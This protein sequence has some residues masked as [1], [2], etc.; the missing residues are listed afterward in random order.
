MAF[1]ENP[2]LKKKRFLHL[3]STIPQLQS[4]QPILR[5]TP[6]KSP[7]TFLDWETIPGPLACQASAISHPPRSSLI[8]KGL[9][10]MML[11]INLWLINVPNLFEAAAATKAAATKA[12]ARTSGSTSSSVSSVVEFWRWWVLKSKVFG[13]ESTCHQGKIFKKFLRVMTVGQKLG[14]ILE[15][16]LVRKLSLEKKNNK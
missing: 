7:S 8:C 13:Q 14:V 15:S 1:S 2:N 9:E 16:E 11:I 12:A 4:N 3:Q 5:P 10:C 6:N